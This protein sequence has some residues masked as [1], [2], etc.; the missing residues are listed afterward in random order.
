[1]PPNEPTIAD[2]LQ[3]LSTQFD[4][5]IEERQLLD[6]VLEQ[7]PSKA[8]N[9]YATIRERLRWDGPALGW[10]RLD[11]SEVVPMHVVLQGLRFRYIPTMWELE[12][13]VLPL[14]RLQPF[15]GLRD[16]TPHLQ[17]A[18]GTPL[19]TADAQ[20]DAYGLRQS[21]GLTHGFA[22]GSWYTQTLFIPGDSIVITILATDP[23]TLQLVHE[24]ATDFR[25]SDVAA[26]DAALVEAIVERVQRSRLP[27]T[28]CDEL[29]LPVFARA[30]WRTGYP[31][32]PWQQLIARDGRLQLVNDVFLTERQNGPTLHRS[33]F[34]L[35]PQDADIEETLAEYQ[36]SREIQLAA[37]IDRL[38]NEL[39]RS[40]QQDVESGL[41]SGQTQ[42]AS[43][44]QPLFDMHGGRSHRF[45]PGPLDLSDDYSAELDA[46]DD[47]D[48]D[49]DN[50]WDDD[51]DD[52]LLHN[53]DDLE[54]DEF[55]QDN[56]DLFE[57]SQ[58]LMLA[59]PPEALERL[60]DATPEQAE[61]IIAAHLNDL[62][63]REPSLF[64]KMDLSPVNNQPGDPPGLDDL[65]GLNDHTPDDTL[66]GESS[67]DS[68]WNDEPE[69]WDSSWDDEWDDDDLDIPIPS[70]Y[71][72][73]SELMSQFYDYLIALGKSESTA[74]SRTRDLWVYAEFLAYYYNRTLAE[75]DY[76][77]LDECLFFFYP[78]KVLNSTP[79]QVREICVS[80]KQFYAFLKEHGVIEDDRFAQALWRR[81]D[82]AARVVEL[83]EQI[84]HD[85]PN[86]ERLFMRLFAPYSL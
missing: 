22:L 82:Q 51:W 79:R 26:Q 19:T 60:Q 10:L 40:R 39:R 66:F 68:L 30:S 7:R 57:A 23:L 25:T 8:K 77:T 5:P 44:G 48:W 49:E 64:V 53:L 81:R 62:L 45:Y 4:G 74:R 21:N 14:V 41:W 38:Q 20:T 1:M 16:A 46:L 27:L 29:I 28:P 75:G 76:A 63:V 31:G 55:I 78:R 58:R 24:S 80:L 70:A 18:T 37:E 85:L 72:H 52:D 32:H 56:P 59:L 34:E 12:A 73:S 69:H 65:S 6:R 9:P 35:S 33:G 43:S 67:L 54:M 71:T 47:N 11:R 17:D 3:A 86:F 36:Q 2:I 84:S 83:Y 50:G 61:V 42:R 15:V 13:G